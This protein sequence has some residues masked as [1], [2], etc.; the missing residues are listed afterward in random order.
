[1]TNLLTGAEPLGQRSMVQECCMDELT[2]NSRPRQSTSLPKAVLDIL[3]KFEEQLNSLMAR[4]EGGDSFSLTPSE[5]SQKSELSRDWCNRDVNK[6]LEDYSV[7][8]TWSDED[9]VEEPSAQPLINVL[10]SMAITIRMAFRKPLS[11]TVRL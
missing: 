9:L 4:V 1:M 8:L 3:A 5:V 10:E 6:R 2:S 7:T 11:N